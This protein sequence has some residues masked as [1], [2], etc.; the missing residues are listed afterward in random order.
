MLSEYS[1]VGYQNDRLSLRNTFLVFYFNSVL[2]RKV[3][4][5]E[6]QFG[7]VAT[8]FGLVS[9]QFGLARGQLGLARGQLGL[10]RGQFGLAKGQFEWLQAI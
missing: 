8:Q 4:L 5:S 2:L 9:N 10:A 6:V 7:L 3:E 1:E